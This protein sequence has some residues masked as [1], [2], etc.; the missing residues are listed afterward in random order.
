LIFAIDTDQSIV[1]G[2]ETNACSRRRSFHRGN[3][4]CAIVAAG[5][6]DAF[7]TD[8]IAAGRANFSDGIDGSAADE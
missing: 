6:I 2:T 3:I 4:Q 8:T 5:Y 7:G 1:A